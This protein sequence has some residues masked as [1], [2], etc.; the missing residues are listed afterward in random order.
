VRVSPAIAPPSDLEV[1][2]TTVPGDWVSSAAC[3]GADPE[4]FFAD[5]GESYTEARA[6]CAE[7]RVIHECRRY[8]DKIE[9]ARGGPVRGLRR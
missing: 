2:V 7:C 3:R 8:V 4:L 9:S 5:K 1:C 6:I